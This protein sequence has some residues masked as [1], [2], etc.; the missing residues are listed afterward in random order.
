MHTHI[1]EGVLV[2]WV[3]GGHWVPCSISL[4]ILL[5]QVLSLNVEMVGDHQAP[6]SLFLLPTMLWS[7][8]FWPQPSVYMF[9]EDLN[10][11]LHACITSNF[12]CCSISLKPRLRF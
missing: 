8:L 3:G 6:E 7:Q 4:S 9:A 5:E 12:I 11:C 1:W 2:C 10:S